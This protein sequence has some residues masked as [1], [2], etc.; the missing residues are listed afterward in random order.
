MRK[1]CWLLLVCSGCASQLDLREGDCSITLV[2]VDAEAATPMFGSVEADGCMLV[3]R[4]ERCPGL[5]KIKMKTHECSF[6]LSE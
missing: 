5:N 4:G 6:G 3:S 2:A 1:I